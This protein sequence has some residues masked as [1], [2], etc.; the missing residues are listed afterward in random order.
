MLLP[1]ANPK[2]VTADLSH[3]QV[4]LLAKTV[5]EEFGIEAENV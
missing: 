3:R 2:N 4:A 5:K 1:F